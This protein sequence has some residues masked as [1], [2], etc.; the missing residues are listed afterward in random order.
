MDLADVASYFDDIPVRDAYTNALLPYE[1][2]FS[3]FNETDPDGSVS[4]SRTISMAS[5]VALPA[6]GVL[7]LMGETWIVGQTSQDGFQGS[8]IRKQAPMRRVTDLF[9]LRTP[10]Q[11]VA[12]SGGLTAYG[13]KDYLMD[14]VDSGTSADYYPFYNVFFAGSELAPARG[15]FFQAPGVLLRCRSTY[16]AKDGMLCAQADLVDASARTYAD[17]GGTTY[18]PVTESYGPS[19]DRRDVLALLPHQLYLKT[20]KSSHSFDPGDLTLLVGVSGTVT[21]GQRL[22]LHLDPLPWLGTSGSAQYQVLS[23][24]LEVDAWNLHV[25]RV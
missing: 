4:N 12:Q 17:F 23:K 20:G 13:R 24:T 7:T 11:A 9:T 21:P 8:A 6:R 3:T 5:S 15:V 25:R 10:A 2:Q 18:D 19:T 16:T 1:V 14:K 22:S